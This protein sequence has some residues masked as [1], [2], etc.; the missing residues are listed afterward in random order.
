MNIKL[1]ELQKL[2]NQ[3]DEKIN[4]E[5]QPIFTDMICYI[6]AAD[7]SD[8][9]QELV[10]Q[11]L[12]EMIISA[13]ERNEDIYSV[14]GGDF[15][16]FC[17]EVIAN[18]PPK[19]MKEK[20]IDI[21]DIFCMSMSILGLI[22]IVFSKDLYRIVNELVSNQQVNYKI[23]I[24]AGMVVFTAIAILA[25]FLIVNNI[26]KNALDKTPGSSKFKKAVLGGSIAAAVIG[27]FLIIWKLNNYILFSVNIFIAL[28]AIIGFFA[29][30]K[31]LSHG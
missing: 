23:S 8:Y 29:A 31:L 14:I 15:R 27:V 4:A 21:F 16:I 10:R 11:D 12:S 22:N 25:A 20:L 17:N 24:S 5:N 3:L 19:T 18:I 26:C 2:N 9:N 28:A 1:K 30:H 13:Q 7:I 6:R